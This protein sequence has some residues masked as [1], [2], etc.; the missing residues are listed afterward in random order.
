MRVKNSGNSKRFLFCWLL[1]CLEATPGDAQ[2]L[3]LTLH[4][5]L[6][7]GSIQG[8]IRDAKNQMWFCHMQGKHHLQCTMTLRDYFFH[9]FPG[10]Q[11]PRE[12]FTLLEPSHLAQT[13]ACPAFPGHSSHSELQPSS[14]QVAPFS[15]VSCTLQGGFCP[16]DRPDCFQPPPLFLCSPGT[17]FLHF[18]LWLSLTPPPVL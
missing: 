1:F 14:L 4:S 18:Y 2:S 16:A 8:T 3:F 10:K 7:L 6:T 13:T 5:S 11:S 15:L 9:S 17:C 12:V